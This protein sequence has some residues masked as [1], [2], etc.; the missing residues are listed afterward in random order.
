MAHFFISRVA[1]NFIDKRTV[2]QIKREFP[3]LQLSERY[4]RQLA[5]SGEIPTV[6]AGNKILIN[7]DK[8][9]DFLNGDL[10]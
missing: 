6:Q 2:M 9:F 8:L 1:Q 5:K 7:V 10:H 4:L 3:Q